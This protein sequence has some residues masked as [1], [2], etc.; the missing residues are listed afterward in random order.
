MEFREFRN[1]DVIPASN[2]LANRHRRE[3]TV[4][5]TLKKEFEDR[6]YTENILNELM[7][8][9][10]VKGICAYEDDK[11]LGFLLS[12]IK[13][14]SRFGRCAWISYEG[15][16][17]ADS[18]TPELYRKLY[19]EIAKIWVKN[20]VLSHYIVVPAGYQE[21]VDSWLK[22]SFAF[23]QVHG[24]TSLSKTDV[25]IPDN[26]IIRQA[27]EKDSEELRKISNLI[28]SYQAESPTYAA[29]LPEDVV[30]IREGYGQFPADSDATV[31]L[32]YNDNTLLGFQCGYIEEAK[33]CYSR[34]LE[35]NKNHEDFGSFKVFEKNT[36]TFMGSGAL[37]VNN[38]STEAEIEYM[39]LP[40]YWGKGY[41]SE[42]VNELL[43]KAKETKSIQQ[44]TAIIAPN[45]IASRKILLRNGFVSFKTY[46]ID[47]GSPA[48]MFSKNIIH[49]IL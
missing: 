22:L 18:E 1:E 17:I 6:N 13:M 48:E 33:K 31:L 26:L 11:L 35:S 15:Q 32:A 30:A 2:L 37:I 3:R 41:G 40:E 43:N 7:K 4:F 10:Y 20:G 16:A 36:S 49:S 28:I 24:I 21:V 19:T 27:A 8:S 9:R 38:D 34:M 5:P 44:V 12:N 39:L 46:K 14:D 47:D 25:N 29:G 42:I 45:N 23:Q